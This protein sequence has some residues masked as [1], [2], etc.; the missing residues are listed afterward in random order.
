MSDGR[1]ERAMD[2]QI[3][4]KKELS[5][6]AK[7]LIYWSIFVPALTYGCNIWVVT[8]PPA[9][10]PYRKESVEVVQASS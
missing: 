9:A 7:L 1:L 4:V 8:L 10:L 3:V 2:R 6:K 5:Q